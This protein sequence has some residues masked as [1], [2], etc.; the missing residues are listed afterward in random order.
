MR[1]MPN[2]KTAAEKAGEEV[3][4]FIEDFYAVSDDA[5]RDGEWVACFAE[6]ATLWMCAKGAK[7]LDEIRELRKGMWETVKRRKHK[8]DKIFFPAAFSR[9]A[10]NARD[11]MTSGCEE[12]EDEEEERVEYMLNGSVDLEMG[13]SE[14]GGGGGKRTVRWAARAV[15]RFITDAGDS[16]GAGTWK[17]E[18]YQ[19]WL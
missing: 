8:V 3:K 12:E 11:D 7:G 6:D 1:I 5:S 14:G 4:R 9:P 17:Y 10:N 16:A 2:K 15:V 13:E 19:V 18:F